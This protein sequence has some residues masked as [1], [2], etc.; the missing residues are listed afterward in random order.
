MDTA[1]DGGEARQQQ[2]ACGGGLALDLG[3]RPLGGKR[4]KREKR[5]LVVVVWG[6]YSD[7]AAAWWRSVVRRRAAAP[8]WLHSGRGR[9][10]RQRKKKGRRG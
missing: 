1:G 4:E 9:S 3:S 10:S 7:Q 6:W 8:A 5:W 2:S